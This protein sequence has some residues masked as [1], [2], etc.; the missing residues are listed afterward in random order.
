MDPETSELLRRD[1][2]HEERGKHR[3]CNTDSV[4]MQ[5]MRCVRIDSCVQHLLNTR[6]L[7]HSL[8]RDPRPQVEVWLRESRKSTISN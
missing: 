7:Q 6:H 1:D 3:K 2:I 8:Y 4:A 5:V